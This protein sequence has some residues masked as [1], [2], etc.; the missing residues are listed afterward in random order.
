MTTGRINQ[1]TIVRPWG[2]SAPRAAAEE[3]LLQDRAGHRSG[4][5]R[6]HR[7]GGLSA[8][9]TGAPEASG[10]PPLVPQ[11]PVHRARRG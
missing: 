11:S 7:R 2:P 8:G 9:P 1:V 10:F 4:E 3:I 5:R 6:S